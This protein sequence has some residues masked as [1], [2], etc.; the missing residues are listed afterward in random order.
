M[1]TGCKFDNYK[2]FVSGHL[3]LRPLTILLGANGVGKTSLLQILQL[4]QQ[5]HAASTAR[6]KSALKLHGRS[7]SMGDA[8]SLFHQRDT[9]TPL[10]LSFEIVDE[11][12]QRYLSSRLVNDF[13]QRISTLHAYIFYLA[14]RRQEK[15]SQLQSRLHSNPFRPTTPLRDTKDF[16]NE[17]SL[18][19]EGLPPAEAAMLP[20][21]L[22][23][24]DRGERHPAPSS[25]KLQ[26]GD[27][28]SVYDFLASLEE[29]KSPRFDL[30][31]EIR[32][33]K[34]AELLRVAAMSIRSQDSKTVHLR[35][36]ETGEVREIN[37]DFIDAKYL[38][39]CKPVLT[40]F[41]EL[42]GTLY[43]IF[44]NEATFEEK[45]R[46]AT[47]LQSIVGAALAALGRCFDEDHLHHVGPLRAYQRDSIFWI[48]RM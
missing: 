2:A 35:F 10:S 24:N 5:T 16:F 30:D 38:N 44:R 33:S 3:Q 45:P 17:L 39:A 7:V 47:L 48:L 23:E 13:K 41:V 28:E 36:S 34:K 1:L 40:H 6:Y 22:A 46:L 37:S 8:E 4:M 43:R 21:L 27:L 20:S 15:S 14:S 32:Y 19:R 12:L 9:D 31:F 18:M 26:S 29:L 11:T 25:S 42:Q